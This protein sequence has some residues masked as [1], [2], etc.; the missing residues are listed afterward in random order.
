M[1]NLQEMVSVGTFGNCGY[2]TRSWYEWYDVYQGRGMCGIYAGHHCF[3][4]SQP[5]LRQRY[6]YFVSFCYL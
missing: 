6:H 4:G 3:V 1:N 5:T 2:Y